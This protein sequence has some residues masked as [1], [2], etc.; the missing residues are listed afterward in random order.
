MDEEAIYKQYREKIFILIRIKTNY[1]D[2]SEDICQDVLETVIQS[3]QDGKINNP[4]KLPA[5]IN[6]ICSNKITDW[7]RHKYAK[8]E[9]ELK[10]YSSGSE[11]RDPEKNALDRLIEEE[12]KN[13]LDRTLR[14]LN[15]RERKILYLHYYHNWAFD[16]I[17]RFMNLK[18]LTVRK[19]AERSRKK[20]AKKFAINY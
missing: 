4:E 13:R 9:N 19:I 6:S 20:I 7:I 1:H 12:E 8:K 10:F 3:V 14:G 11:I 2:D 17:A 16:E 5:F 18:S 15:L